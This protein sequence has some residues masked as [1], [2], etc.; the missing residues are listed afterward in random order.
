MKR[1]DLFSPLFFCADGFSRRIA[2]KIAP[3]R[4]M[5]FS[6]QRVEKKAPDPLNGLQHS[7]ARNK[8]NIPTIP[9][10]GIKTYTPRRQSVYRQCDGGHL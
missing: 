3:T 6:M 10:S 4:C 9:Y 1:V 8:I 5:A 7:P 2:N